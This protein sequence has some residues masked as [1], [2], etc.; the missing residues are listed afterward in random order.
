MRLL[1]TKLSVQGLADDS[2]LGIIER[3]IFPR[4]RM[5]NFLISQLILTMYSFR[6]SP[7]GIALCATLLLIVAAL[8]FSLPD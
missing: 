6:C 3:T 2:G 1:A 7:R 8:I 4:V 5:I